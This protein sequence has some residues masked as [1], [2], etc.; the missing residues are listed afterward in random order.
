MLRASISILPTHPR[1]RFLTLGDCVYTFRS[2][3]LVS[4][5]G[6]NVFVSPVA[7]TQFADDVRVTYH[8]PDYMPVP[9]DSHVSLV[10]WNPGRWRRELTNRFLSASASIFFSLSLT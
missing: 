2:N 5:P 9:T 1:L 6:P 4:M 10:V 3:R 7:E 8:V